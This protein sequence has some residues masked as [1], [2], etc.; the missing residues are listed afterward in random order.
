M[1][2]GAEGTC[3]GVFS[4]VLGEG[5]FPKWNLDNGSW[6]GDKKCGEC[7]GLKEQH[8]GEKPSKS[9]KAHT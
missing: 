3:I 5:L 9:H 7:S 6:S 8:R 2:L 1:T 4:P